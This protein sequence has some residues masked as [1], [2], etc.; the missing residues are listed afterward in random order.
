MAD[1]L[2]QLVCLVFVPSLLLLLLPGLLLPGLPVLW[3][4]APGK[5]VQDWDFLLL[6]TV[7]LTEGFLVQAF[8]PVGG[9][10]A[11]GYFVLVFFEG[12]LC[13]LGPPSIYI[14]SHFYTLYYLPSTLYIGGSIRDRCKLFPRPPQI[15]CSSINK[16]THFKE[17]PFLPKFV[18]E[19]A[20]QALDVV[21][22][23]FSKWFSC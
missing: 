19:G 10:G 16:S 3:A 20:Y 15:P 9:G 18:L 6:F 21:V 14:F 22:F 5:E 8:T 7:W 13:E 2:I 23:F 4:L 11:S 17:R 12:F 1:E